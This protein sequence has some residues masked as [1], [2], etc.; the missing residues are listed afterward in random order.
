MNSK[1]A[2]IASVETSP[3]WSVK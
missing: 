2:S 1:M 3:D